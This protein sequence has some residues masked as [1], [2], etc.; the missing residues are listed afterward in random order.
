L[1]SHGGKHYLAGRVIAMM[2]PHLHYVEAFFGSGQVLFARDPA[3]RRLWWPGATSDGRRA[4]GVSEVVNDL[5][6]DLMNL[7][8]VLKD[9]R[10]T[11]RLQHRLRLTLVSEDEW[12]DAKAVLAGGGGDL[13]ARAAALFVRVRQ[14]RQ[15]LR[16]DFVTPVPSRLRGGRQ[17]HVNAWWSAI[18]GLEDAHRRLRDV[19]VL[20]R[21]ALDVIRSQ[22]GPA[23]LF[24]LDPPY[25]HETRTA[26]KAYGAFEMTE[27]D[28]RDLLAV[29]KGVEGH[30]LLSGYRNPL[31]DEALGGWARV[32]VEL[33]NN[34]SAG[35]SKRRM[36]ESIWTNRPLPGRLQSRPDLFAGQGG[37]S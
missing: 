33:P 12:T 18:D 27:Q 13:V 21:P 6:G 30:V 2:T 28:H 36:I 35:T 11:E 8:R 23:T 25:L 31:Y 16:K 22:D 5:D 26:R 7:Y 14:S 34:A 24:Y 37:Q 1:K 4:D 17:E 29:L 32:D 10:L 9:P 15:A 19:L 3:D 20:N